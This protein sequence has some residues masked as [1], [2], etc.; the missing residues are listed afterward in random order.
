MTEPSS[1]EHSV[2]TRHMLELHMRETD[3]LRTAQNQII[4]DK[5]DRQEGIMK[6]AGGL[7]FSLI[8]AV[9]GWSLLQQISANSAQMENNE[10]QIELLRERDRTRV[11]TEELQALT[12]N[13]RRTETPHTPRR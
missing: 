12:T 2:T 1:M 5:L 6:W 8:L 10:K 13:A 7:L 9:L 4:N 3:L 11:L